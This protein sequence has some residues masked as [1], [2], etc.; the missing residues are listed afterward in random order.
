MVMTAVRFGRI[1]LWGGGENWRPLVSNN[2]VA[3]IYEK[4]SFWS[5]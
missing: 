4:F 5:K 2:D 1:E 3:R